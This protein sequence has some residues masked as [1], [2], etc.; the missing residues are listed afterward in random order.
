MIR[1]AITEMAIV[2]LIGGLITYGLLWLFAAV[3]L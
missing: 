2:A 1:R 3:W